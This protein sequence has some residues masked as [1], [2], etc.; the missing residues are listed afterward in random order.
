MAYSWNFKWLLSF[1]FNNW[2]EVKKGWA[3]STLNGSFMSKIFRRHSNGLQ[4]AFSSETRRTRWKHFVR[5]GV[6]YIHFHLMNSE[7]ICHHSECSGS[8]G[9]VN[10]SCFSRRYRFLSLSAKHR[11]LKAI[12]VLIYDEGMIGQ[13]VSKS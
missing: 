11:N 5:T 4:F 1:V 10:C 2:L 6:S 9:A 8:R 12:I 7:I 13:K 3:T